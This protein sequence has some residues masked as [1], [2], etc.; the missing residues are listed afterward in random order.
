MFESRGHGW[1]VQH[2]EVALLGFGRGDVA[3][4]FQQPAIV[5]PVDP[6]EGCELDSLE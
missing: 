1:V 5:E 2:G 4:G 3:D 6:L